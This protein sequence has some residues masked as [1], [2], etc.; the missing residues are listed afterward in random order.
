MAPQTRTQRTAAAKKAAAT[1]KRNASNR[2]RSNTK[3]ATRRAD[4]EV[5]RAEAFAR[6]V[7]RVVLVPVGALLSATDSLND[8]LST[9]N[10]LQ[11]TLK[12]FERRGE[13]AL[14]RNRRKATAQ[15]RRTRTQAKRQVK[16]TRRD[17]G[18]ETDQFVGRVQD[19]LTAVGS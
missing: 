6:Q 5:T 10:G 19:R 17:I 18:R 8:T 9:R 16:S 15:V 2:S 12:R 3:R 14:R 11:R 1:R 13:T 7:E 4:A